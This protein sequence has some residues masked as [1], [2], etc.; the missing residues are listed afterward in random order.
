MIIHTIKKRIYLQREEN[1]AS[2]HPSFLHRCFHFNLL[3][4][5]V[6]LPSLWFLCYHRYDTFILNSRKPHMISK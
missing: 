1:T 6:F 2:L 5:D 4:L 3:L